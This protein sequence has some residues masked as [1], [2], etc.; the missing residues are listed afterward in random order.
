MKTTLEFPDSIFRRAK[1]RAAEEQKSLRQFVTEALVDK[2][3]SKQ[4]DLR[5]ARLKLGGKLKH[6][7]HETARINAI[8]EREFE[9]IDEESA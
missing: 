3:N 9:R 8:M 7:R 6:L 4:P 1:A 2:L 5:S